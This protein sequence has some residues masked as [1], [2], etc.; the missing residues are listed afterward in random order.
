VPHTEGIPLTDAISWDV[1]L[2]C[3]G[4]QL[5]MFRQIVEPPSSVLS[6][7]IDCLTMKVLPSFETWAST[8]HTQQERHAPE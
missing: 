3:W 4:K 5:L 2:S 1:P 7:D 6:R 8:V